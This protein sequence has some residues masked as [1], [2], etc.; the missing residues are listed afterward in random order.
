VTERTVERA[1]GRMTDRYLAV[2]YG[3]LGYLIGDM[4]LAPDKIRVVY[5]AVDAALYEPPA[6]RDD[7]VAAELGA[8][9]GDF[10]VGSIA[11]L[12]AEKDHETLLRAF[13]LALRDAPR[14]R[15]AVVGD[16]PRRGVLEELARTLGIG[17]RVRFVGHR[18]DVT[19]VLRASTP[20]SSPPERSRTSRTRCS[21]PW[22]WRV[23][24]SAPP[25][26]A[27]PR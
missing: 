26:G 11:V 5:N 27:C 12:R 8:A 18:S 24:P 25:S 23:P 21:S 3:Q 15:L 9:P 2:S 19:R 6:V 13:S 20:P 7:E 16:G 22:P 17:D 10:L 4:R 1:L 14:L